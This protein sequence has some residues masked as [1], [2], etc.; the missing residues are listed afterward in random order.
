MAGEIVVDADLLGDAGRL[1]AFSAQPKETPATSPEYRRL[2]ARFA[3][4]PEFALA[5]E[6]VAAGLG[7]VIDVHETAGLLAIANADS[8]LRRPTAEMVARTTPTRRSLLGVALLGIAAVAYRTPGRLADPGAVSEFSVNS[9]VDHLDR[10]AARLA[11]NAEDPEAGRPELAE[12]HRAWATLNSA[13]AREQRTSMTNRPG[14]IRKVCNLLVDAGQLRKAS[15]LDGGTYRT[16]P[17]FAVTLAS[18]VE[19]S[20]IFSSLLAARA[21]S[22]T[23][24]AGDTHPDPG[25]SDTE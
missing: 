24:D 25:D 19:D 14:L 1:L 7:L 18:M 17:R 11:E 4:E 8:P 13:R 6:A 5:T 23:G 10:L 20:D 9:V 16:T 21:A 3:D 22:D 12:V 2:L 15:D